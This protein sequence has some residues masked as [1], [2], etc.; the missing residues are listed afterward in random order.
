[1]IRRCRCGLRG[2]LRLDSICPWRCAFWQSDA[3][4][5]CSSDK[6]SEA[7]GIVFDAILKTTTRGRLSRSFTAPATRFPLH[8]LVRESLVKTPST[9]APCCPGQKSNEWLDS[10]LYVPGVIV[11]SCYAVCLILNAAFCTLHTCGRSHVAR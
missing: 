4:G 5:L 7:D 9:A 11:Q 8:K 2:Y 10:R 6:L 3:V 1:M